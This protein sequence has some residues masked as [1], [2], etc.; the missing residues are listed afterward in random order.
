[1]DAAS[2][3][4]LEKGYRQAQ[5]SDIARAMGVAPG[6]VYLYVESKEALFELTLRCAMRA[7]WISGAAEFPIRRT[8][9]A[10]VLAFIRETLAREMQFPVLSSVGGTPTPTEARRELEA[11]VRELFQSTSRNWLALK[12]LERSAPDWPELAALWFGQHRP[13]LFL[14]VVE[15]FERR[16]SAQ[17]LRRA[18]DISVA[19]RLV[20]EMV[21]AM[22]MHCRT[23]SYSPPLDPD[24][25]ETVVVDAVVQAYGQPETA[26][27]PKGLK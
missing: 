12:L 6:T 8:S 24:V 16:M 3:V 1:M 21:A 26:S 10:A 19:A 7:D 20:I 15:Y 5:M 23:D 18:P 25:A 4:F 13:Q 27:E 11:V 9:E 2:R 17:A 22:A 14:L